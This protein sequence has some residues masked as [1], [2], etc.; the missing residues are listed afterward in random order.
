MYQRS[1]DIGLGVPFNIASYALLTRI[2]AHL[3]KL[4]PGK[5]IHIIGDAHIYL[6]HIEQLKIQIE[7]QPM[8]FPTLTLHDSIPQLSENP[9]QN[10][11]NHIIHNCLSKEKFQLHDYTPYTSIKMNMAV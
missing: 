10:E 5:L 8:Q 11:I 9:D 2:V 3:L 4:K 1:A 6:D 7:R